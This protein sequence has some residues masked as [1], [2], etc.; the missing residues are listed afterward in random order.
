M[1]LTT[2]I[3]TGTGTSNFHLQTGFTLASGST[4]QTLGDRLFI[5]GHSVTMSTTTATATT[6][7]TLN[8]PKSG[9]GGGCIVY[10]NVVATDGTNY[11]T[12]TG[13]FSVSAVNKAGTVTASAAAI[14][15]E[16]SVN[17]GA[18]TL[19]AGTTSTSVTSTAVAIL[20]A[21]AW[22]TLV[23]TSVTCTVTVTP[24]GNGVTVT[25]D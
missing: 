24:F 23:P 25:P 18:D 21:P 15:D 16:S 13:S 17:S 5:A 7:T 14:T 19:T 10:Y 22:A 3:P 9:S 12:A 6:I 1:L 11:S 4:A 8:V 2:G 20:V